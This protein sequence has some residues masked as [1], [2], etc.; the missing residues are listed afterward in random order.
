VRFESRRKAAIS[1]G[2]SKIAEEFR[3]RR[4]ADHG[5]CR[6]RMKSVGRQASSDATES[7]QA[8]RRGQVIQ[9]RKGFKRALG[10]SPDITDAHNYLGNEHS[11]EL[12]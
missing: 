2:C 4:A 11:F 9:R 12:S 7:A 5:Y 8:T 6:L 1:S 3:L 10:I